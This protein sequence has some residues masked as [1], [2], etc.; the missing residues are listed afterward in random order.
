MRQRS[1]LHDA[2]CRSGEEVGLDARSRH[3]AA[4]RRLPAR[5][6]W[7]DRARRRGGRG[8]DGGALRRRRRARALR[9]SPGQPAHAGAGGRRLRCGSPPTK[10]SPAWRAASA[11]R[12][13][14][15]SAPFEPE[16]GAYAGGHH[17][18]SGDAKHGGIIHDMDRRARGS[19]AMS[20]DARA[21]ARATAAAREPGA[22]DRRLQLFAG[23]RVGGGGGH[24]ARC[25]ERER[26]DRR[27]DGIRDR[28][29]RGGRAVALRARRCS[30]RPADVRSSGTR[31]S[32][33]RARPRS[34]ARKPSR[35]APR[36]SSCWVNSTCSTRR[37]ARR[38]ARG[39]PIT[40]PAAFALAAHR[41]RG[42]A[43]DTRWQA[44]CGRGSKTRC[45]RR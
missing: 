36:W 34:C 33:H 27:P 37:R 17:H 23:P 39:T 3:G 43:P 13:T 1:R 4:R 5:G 20:D 15:I 38:V 25:G 35:R 29:G 16:A 21:C 42:S 28:A 31:G 11:R 18:H 10:C 30:G 6:R 40:L 26:L 7:P 14:S 9:V 12:S 44:T 2:A 8:A 24:R 22:A 41:V 45:S 19:S 32:A